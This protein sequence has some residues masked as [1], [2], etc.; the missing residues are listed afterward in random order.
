[1]L[2]PSNIQKQCICLGLFSVACLVL[3]RVFVAAGLFRVAVQLTDVFLIVL[4]EHIRGFF[5]RILKVY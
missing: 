1:M 5:T 2:H 4:M 3:S